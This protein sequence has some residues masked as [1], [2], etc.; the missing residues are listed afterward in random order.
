MREAI[1]SF[2]RSLRASPASGLFGCDLVCSVGNPECERPDQSGPAESE[3]CEELLTW[4]IVLGVRSCLF[5][6]P[7]GSGVAPK[8]P[9]IAGEDFRP[10]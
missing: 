1:T 9:K 7:L 8:V 2:S 10:E 6:W 5:G 3:F 4:F